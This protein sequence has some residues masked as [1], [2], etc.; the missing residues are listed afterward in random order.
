MRGSG[1]TPPISAPDGGVT[2]LVLAIH[3]AAD[4]T[5]TLNSVEKLVRDVNSGWLRET[6]AI[7]SPC[8]S[9]PLRA[10]H[11]QSAARSDVARHFR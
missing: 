11:G 2:G 1:T 10:R 4:T 3:C 6:P 9:R 5:L 8:G 7:D